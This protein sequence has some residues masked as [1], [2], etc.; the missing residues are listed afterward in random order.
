MNSQRYKD[1]TGGM[2][3]NGARMGW[4]MKCSKGES[5]FGIRGSRIFELTLTKDGRVVGEYNLGWSM[6]IPE[7]DE[8]SALCLAYLVDRFGRNAPRKK[9][10]R[11]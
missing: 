4:T 1:Q 10:T 8:E 6:K 3:I 5:A 9:E 7:E 11:K 2:T